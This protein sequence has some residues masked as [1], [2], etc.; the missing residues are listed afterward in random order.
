MASYSELDPV[1]TQY[2]RLVMAMAEIQA[3]GRAAVAD[4]LAAGRARRLRT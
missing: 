2:D 4:A 3:K 1:V